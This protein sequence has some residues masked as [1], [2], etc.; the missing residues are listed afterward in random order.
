M[1][2][3][4]T[5][6]RPDGPGDGL[7]AALA[8]EL[9]ALR[10]KAQERDQYLA[11]LQRTQADFENYQKRSR[12]EREDEWK[13]RHADLARELLPVID[14]LERAMAAAKQA[15]ETGPLVQGVTMVQGQFV[16]LLR[17]YGI[18]R[19][20]AQGKPFDPHLHQAVM[21]QP[22]N[23]YPPGTVVQ[24]LEPGYLIHDRVL[25]DA[26][27]AVSVPAEGKP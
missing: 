10:A 22:T 15:G 24:V 26:R 8:G 5:T 13:Y 12:R 21:Q 19:M 4:E 25:R 6:T 18:T 7:A 11:M 14:N 20:D 1:A 17:R 9:Q 23:D 3:P 16:D 2:E 27:V